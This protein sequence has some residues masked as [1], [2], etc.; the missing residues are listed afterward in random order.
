M[1]YIYAMDHVI[2]IKDIFFVTD[3]QFINGSISHFSFPLYS[4]FLLI[5]SIFM[6]VSSANKNISNEQKAYKTKT[7]MLFCCVLM[8]LFLLI[9]STT[10][11]KKNNFINASLNN[12]L[13]LLFS[14]QTTYT[15]DF[16]NEIMEKIQINGL[17]SEGNKLVDL[18]M[19]NKKNIIMVV[20]E[21]IPGAYLSEVQKYFNVDNNITLTSLDEIKE[22]SIVVPNF[23]THNNQT[24]RGLY[25][26]FSGDYPKL[27]SSTPKAFEYLQQKN[28]NA[29]M[30]PNELKK[31]GYNTT[32]IQAAPLEFMSKDRFMSEIGFDNV[33]GSEG[34]SYNYIPFGW[35]VD[36][37]AFFEQSI[38]Y[39]DEINNQGKPWF[40]TL[41][42]VGT[43]HPYAVPDDLEKKHS[44]RKDAA[45]E[46]L[47]SALKPF[48]D[49]IKN[50]EYA[51][52]TLILFISDESHGVN[53]QPYGSNWG[54]CI[55]YSPDIKQ[56]VINNNIF[57][58]KDIYSS[59]MDYID[60]TSSNYNTG[61]SIFR[62]YKREDPI[63]FASHLNGDVFYSSEI[64]KVVLLNNKNELLSIE[65]SNGKMFS[66]TY[67]ISALNDD[68]LKK[69][70]I[71]FKD[72]INQSSIDSN[73]LSIIDR[74]N[75]EIDH[76]QTEIIT[77]G[78]FITLQENSY[79]NISFD[80]ELKNAKE[81]DNLVFS[82]EDRENMD[83]LNIK[84]VDYRTNKGTMK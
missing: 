30:L 68:F 82:L 38:D 46:Y 81:G 75:V 9:F 83:L 35:G 1:E 29:H 72:F 37:K 64:G 16:P 73:R 62:E 8:E 57:G 69:D 31:L 50:S 43:H 42:T 65:S 53:D 49:T 47:D 20:M 63:L 56:Q 40:V 12:S 2:N 17:V 48:I 23:L 13:T 25:S 79:V 45:V 19:H 27:D 55:V 76:G 71:L 7:Y 34:F 58:L 70:I 24:I 26:I 51:K 3:K 66:D 36:D 52:D 28:A 59:V 74:K 15:E 61:R 14:K 4:S 67:N 6:I 54:T 32:F 77:D 22:N 11:W 21:G 39:I 80:Y 44:N 41:L 60:P 84:S 10:D 18:D 33:V 78:Q 5:I